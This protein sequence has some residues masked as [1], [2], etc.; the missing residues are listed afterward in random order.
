MKPTL[1]R[2]F[3][4]WICEVFGH[5]RELNH[6]HHDICKRCGTTG[7]GSM[8]WQNDSCIRTSRKEL[9]EEEEKMK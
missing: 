2:R 6:I 9:E 8:S 5:R 4:E 7:M 3:T 1:R